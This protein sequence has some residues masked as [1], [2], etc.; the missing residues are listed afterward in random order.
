VLLNVLRYYKCS[1][2]DLSILVAF[3][4][5]KLFPAKLFLKFNM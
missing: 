4:T 2:I 3:G 5:N 1:R